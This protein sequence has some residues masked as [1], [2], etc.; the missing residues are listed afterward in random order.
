MLSPIPCF[1]PVSLSVTHSTHSHS[2]RQSI[3]HPILLTSQSVTHSMFLTR[4]SVSHLFSA[5]KP[6]IQSSSHPI[7]PP[8]P[9]I[10]S[11][12]HLDLAPSHP[13]TET[14]SQGPS[15]M[16]VCI[17]ANLFKRTCLQQAHPSLCLSNSSPRSV[18]L[19][20]WPVC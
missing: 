19:S 3:T 15:H 2:V 17:Y 6:V 1:Q 10:P 9:V 20:P 18:A 16:F 14:V 7:Q 12:G 5:R 13:A 8:Q 11:V 4:H